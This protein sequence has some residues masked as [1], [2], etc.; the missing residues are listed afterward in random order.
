MNAIHQKI[1]NSLEE[2]P[3]FK[4]V[5]KYLPSHFRDMTKQQLVDILPTD[6]SVSWS[7]ADILKEVDR[8]YF[9]AHEY[10]E[11]HSVDLA[12]LK[13]GQLCLR[14]DTLGKISQGQ[15]VYCM[16][17]L[18]WFRSSIED[19]VRFQLLELNLLLRSSSLRE[20]LYLACPS[21]SYPY[22]D[23]FNQFIYPLPTAQLRMWSPALEVLKQGLNSINAIR[24]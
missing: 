7:K 24:D 20:D 14:S 15:T 19:H 8:A 23:N 1:V 9:S 21:E 13:T 3:V 5:Q 6:A 10:F 2:L 12:K 4:V 11:K 18:T 17:G 22:G 16:A